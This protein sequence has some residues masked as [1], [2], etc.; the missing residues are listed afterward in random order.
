MHSTINHSRVFTQSFFFLFRVGS[1]IRAN[2]GREQPGE[3]EH[4]LKHVLHFKIHGLARC[5]KQTISHNTTSR[6]SSD[7]QFQ[8]SHTM[9]YIYSVIMTLENKSKACY[10]KE[11][12][13]WYSFFFQGLKTSS[14]L[15]KINLSLKHTLFFFYCFCFLTLFGLLIWSSA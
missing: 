6:V 8:T 11:M 7:L 10:R 2:V 15:S 14:D 13:H 1:F 9:H 12:M 4:P 5:S 3:Y